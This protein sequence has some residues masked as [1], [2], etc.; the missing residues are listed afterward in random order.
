MTFMP[1]PDP[2]DTGKWLSKSLAGVMLPTFGAFGALGP[3]ALETAQM[4]KCKFAKY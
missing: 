4:L 2:R 1:K 3:M